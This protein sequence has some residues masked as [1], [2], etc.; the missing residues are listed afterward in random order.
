MSAKNRSLPKPHTKAFGNKKTHESEP[1]PLMADQMALAAAEG[2]LEQFM[3]DELPDNEH[4]RKLASMMMGMTGMMPSGGATGMPGQPAA[5]AAASLPETD[6]V[7]APAGPPE[8]II[9]AINTADVSELKELLKREH[10]RRSPDTS[11]TEGPVPP[12]AGERMSPA[13]K[14]VIDEMLR[15]AAE[16]NLTP[17][18]IM[19]R[20]LKVYIEEYKKTGRL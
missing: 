1:L 18:W 19:A 7:Q 2:R 10:A 11:A 15:I 6:P 8:D 4:A 12:S 14:E 13:E 5:P 9:K 16:N 17:D 3:K 20:A